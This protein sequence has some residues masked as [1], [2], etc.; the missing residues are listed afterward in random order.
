MITASFTVPARRSMGPSHRRILA[1][2]VLGFGALV[3][4]SVCAGRGKWC[5]AC[6][7][8]DNFKSVGATTQLEVEKFFSMVNIS[9]G[10]L[11]LRGW[12]PISEEVQFKF[13]SLIIFGVEPLK[14]FQSENSVFTFYVKRIT[15]IPISYSKN[16]EQARIFK[17]WSVI[18]FR[19]FRPWDGYPFF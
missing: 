10:Q 4:W 15:F 2:K 6:P 8:L 7:W 11:R 9:W 18:S 5:V 19:G 17:K 14:H 13:I 16:K 1:L 12:F 3:E